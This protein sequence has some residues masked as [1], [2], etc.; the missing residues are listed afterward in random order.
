MG[1]LFT[2]ATNAELLSA[3]RIRWVDYAKGVGI[4]LVVFGHALGSLV[5]S[6]ILEPSIIV[7]A[8]YQWIY[9]FH[10]PL[11]FFISGLFVHRSASKPLTKFVVD[12]F[13]VIAYP[14]FVWSVLQTVLQVVLSRHVNHPA[15]LADLWQITYK[16]ILEFWFLYTLFVILLIYAVAHKLRVSPVQFLV[17]SILFYYLPRNVELG[18]WGV[19]YLVKYYAL[20]LAIG[21]LVGTTGAISGLR[22]LK[23]PLLLTIASCGFLAVGLAVWLNLVSN[24]LLK[25][26]VALFGIIASVAL[27]ILL[28][29]FSMTGFIEQWGRSSLEIYV[30]HTIASAV[31]RIGL[32]KSCSF[33][34]PSTHLI[35]ETAV[36][37]Y[38]PIVLQK[39]CYRNGFSYMFTLRPN[40]LS[41]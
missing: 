33:V 27:S 12:K 14:Y 35:L 15:T 13:M 21:A 34:E 22:Q 10:M 16:P 31:V 8:S 26:E 25:P 4:F 38:A 37:I 24:E 20:Y 1:K 19:L 23:T 28:E 17:L 6:S 5:D 29:R 32:Q 41:T 3:Q 40:S 30:A 39:I 36:G 9:A 11:F 2:Q 7:R 18:S